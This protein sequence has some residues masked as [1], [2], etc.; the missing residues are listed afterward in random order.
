MNTDTAKI[1]YN[2]TSPIDLDLIFGIDTKLFIDEH[3]HQISVNHHNKEVDIIQIY[4]STGDDNQNPIHNCE[5]PNCEKAFHTTLTENNIE[6]L[7]RKAVTDFLNQLASEYDNCI[8]RVKGFIKLQEEGLFIMNF[9][10]G[11]FELHAV[12][13]RIDENILLKLTVMG[14]DLKRAVAKFEKFFLR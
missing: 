1:H 9:A 14:I 13:G 2:S 7:S 12:S 8:Y 5:G 11:R 6:P 4:S 10:F 3:D